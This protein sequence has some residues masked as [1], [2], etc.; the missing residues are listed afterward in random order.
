MKKIIVN[1]EYNDPIDIKCGGPHI[2]GYDFFI[3]DVNVEEYIV[4]IK[5][6]LKINK[7]PLMEISIRDENREGVHIWNKEEIQKCIKEGY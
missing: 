2:L 1:C 4:F 5:E 7:Q 3:D 6:Q